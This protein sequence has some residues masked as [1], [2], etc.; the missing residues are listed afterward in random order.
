MK[1]R[2]SEI[3]SDGRHYQLDR[4]TGELNEVLRDLIGDS[5]YQVDLFI[6][7]VGNTYEMRGRMQTSIPEVCSQCGWDF[8]YPVNK[9]VHEFLIEENYDH[10]KTQS[11]HGNQAVNFLSDD[12]SVTTVQGSVFDMDAYVHEAVA[13][14]EPFY[15]ICGGDSCLRHDEVEK[16][17]TRLSEEFISD[18]KEKAGHPGFAVLKDLNLKKN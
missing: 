17:R 6:L 16:I 10:R 5:N 15:P 4:E 7:P 14:A 11:V 13:L 18:Q 3:P 12:L 1:I 2:L 9:S 8:V